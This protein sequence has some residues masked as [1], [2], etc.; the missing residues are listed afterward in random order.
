MGTWNTAI[1]GNDTFLDI[2]R[3]FFNLYNQGK[4][5]VDISKKIQEDFGQ[6]FSDYD[7]CNNSLFALALAQWET[8]ALDPAVFNKVKIIIE[9][10]DDLKFWKESNADDKTIKKR[11]VALN[12]FL[13]QISVERDKPKRRVK[14]KF[15]YSSIQLLSITAPD[16]NKT[17][18]IIES[19]VNGEY[20]NTS[21]GVSWS[22]GGG[23][24]FYFHIKGKFITATWI[25]NQTLEIR[26]DKTIDFAKKEEN[27][28]F[29]GD[30]GVIK[31]IAE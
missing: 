23:S 18:Y 19:Y 17:F 30:G 2:Y 14:P 28:F 22:D 27:F 10:E 21:S 15:E 6:M 31:Y 13:K 25:D 9:R 5:P 29:C 26:H 12:K 7:D 3:N 4:N 20:T 8:K 16:N 1:N 11:Q 24:V